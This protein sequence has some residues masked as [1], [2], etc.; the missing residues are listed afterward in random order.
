[1][2]IANLLFSFEGRISRTQFW[3]GVAIVTAVELA[4][5]WVTG[6]S[7]SETSPDRWS[8]IV[9]GVIGLLTIYPTAAIAVKRL[10]DRNQPGAYVWLLV[11]ISFVAAAMDFFGVTDDPANAGLLIW[12]FSAAVL[13]IAIAFLI[14][15]GFRRGTP[16]D[17]RFGPDPLARRA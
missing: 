9:K 16:G 10:H 14:E 8:R 1:M 15:L 13:V 5:L 11:A 6:V 12:I 3:L 4:L 7:F 17:N 2:D